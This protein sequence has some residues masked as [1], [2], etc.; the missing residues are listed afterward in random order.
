MQ[1]QTSRSCQ[2]A[3]VRKLLV[4]G[5]VA[6]KKYVMI[7]VSHIQRKTLVYYRRESRIVRIFV[8]TLIQTIITQYYVS[9]FTL[10]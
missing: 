9:N 2:H 10:P 8:F 4:I 5:L 7:L 6:Q 3:D 1:Q